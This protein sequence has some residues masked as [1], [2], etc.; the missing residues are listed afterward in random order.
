MAR[1]TLQ[2][3]QAYDSA[4]GRAVAH[5]DSAAMDSL[6]VERGDAIT[7]E[8]DDQTVVTVERQRADDKAVE[9][10][11]I[12]GF[13]R[14]NAGVEP[15]E[16]VDIEPVATA[17]ADTVT[18]RPATPQ[19]CPIDTSHA[20]QVTNKLFDTPMLTG[21]RRWVMVGPQEPFGVV[22]GS[23][24]P[25]EVVET[26]PERAVVITHS[27]DLTI[28]S[29]IDDVDEGGTASDVETWERLRETVFERD[30]RTCRNCGI[31]LDVGSVT[32]EAHFVVTPQ[33]GGVVAP[34]NV[35]TLCRECH[36]AAHQHVTTPLV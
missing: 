4:R 9:A 15:E 31:D 16:S 10:V 26:D 18:V 24:R 33:H 27:T 19:C 36:S 1:E 32:L 22:V 12:G 7:L 34:D 29:A 20:A 3:E 17:E 13:T 28:E 30:G 23:W 14:Q 35:V 21:E 2:V 25:L 6:G 5:L 11:R 8:G